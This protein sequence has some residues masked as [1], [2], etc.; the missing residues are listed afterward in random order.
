MILVSGGSGYV[1][2]HIVR[3]LVQDGRRVRAMVR[4][5]ARAENEG[6]LRGLDVECVTADVTRPE[7]LPS[8]LA[9]A[10]AVVHTVAIAI[11]RGSRKYEE[12][13][14]QGTVNIV[15]AA[16]MAGVKRFVNMC[17]LGADASLPYRFLA[18]KGKAQD[19]VAQSGLDWTAFRPSVIWGPQDEFA[20]T[21]AR[22][23]PLTPIIFPIVGDENARFQPVWV[24]D[25]ATA[26]AGALEDSGTIGGDYEL[27]GPEVLTLEEIERRT[28]A[29]LGARRLLVR[30]PL[31]ALRLV[32]TLM[33]ALLPA[34][35]VTRSLLELL[36]VSNVTTANALHRF[37]SE[38]RPFTSENAAAYMRAFRV[39]E[40]IRQ[41]LSA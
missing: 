14:Y 20:N 40:T 19:F 33:E 29:A 18:S 31:P 36:A 23:V 24:E 28:L 21:F 41:F 6:R 4:D 13:N 9:G 26:V 30:F 17:Q 34:P 2:S 35:P 22:L 37:V 8:A 16:K 32:V 12:I 1:G 11:E 38:P 5:A 25:V 7:T 15:A 3:R 27:G 10:D 39:G